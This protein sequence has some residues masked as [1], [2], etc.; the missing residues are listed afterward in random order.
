MKHLFIKYSNTFLTFLSFLII[1]VTISLIVGYSVRIYTLNSSHNNTFSSRAVSFTVSGTDI[2]DIPE[3]KDAGV[4]RINDDAPFSAYE[5]LYADVDLSVVGKT[6]IDESF[7]D[8]NNA[9]VGSQVREI[10]DVDH[11]VINNTEYNVVKVFEDDT[12]PSNNFAVFYSGKPQANVKNGLF[13]IDGKN[14]RAV[15][16]EL[17]AVKKQAESNGGKIQIE[18]ENKV[19]ISNFIKFRKSLIILSLLAILVLVFSNVMICV[20]RLDS[21]KDMLCVYILL[22]KGSIFKPVFKALIIPMLS[23]LLIC[24]ALPIAMGFGIMTTVFSTILTLLI[25]VIVDLAT[26]SFFTKKYQNTE[27]GVLVE[28]QNE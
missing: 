7:F 10:Y 27:N 11:L 20:F 24:S 23:A 15:E 1:A 5:V 25:M 26:S 22:G 4:F 17:S 12:V 16:K 13:F 3:V 8:G 6:V 19:G 14:R 2:I 21:I 28:L 18:Q 9:I